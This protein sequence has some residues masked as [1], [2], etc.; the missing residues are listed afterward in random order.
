MDNYERLN[1]DLFKNNDSDRDIVFSIVR[2]PKKG[3][4][5]LRFDQKISTL[6]LISKFDTKLFRD[7][8]NLNRP[9]LDN[10]I[11]KNSPDLSD[12][13]NITSYLKIK[14]FPYES[15]SKTYSNEDSSLRIV[16]KDTKTLFILKSPMVFA[17][18]EHLKTNNSKED[19][20]KQ[21]QSFTI[22]KIKS[23]KEIR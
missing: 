13:L 1:Y 21:P 12:A 7:F 6:P 3:G 20:Y 5:C 11:S 18:L 15:E 19:S 14:G 8:L 9:I 10:S 17:Y 4:N 16:Y 23:K 22:T 2:D